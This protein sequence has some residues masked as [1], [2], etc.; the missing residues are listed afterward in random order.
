MRKFKINFKTKIL[1]KSFIKKLFKI[2]NNNKIKLFLNM[3]KI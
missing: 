1:D 2:H 3:K